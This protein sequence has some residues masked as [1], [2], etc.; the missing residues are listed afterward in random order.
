MGNSGKTTLF[1]YKEK[2]SKFKIKIIFCQD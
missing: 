1:F 2:L